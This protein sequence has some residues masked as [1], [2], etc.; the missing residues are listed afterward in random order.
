[1]REASKKRGRGVNYK[2]C[3]VLKSFKKYYTVVFEDGLLYP[4]PSTRDHRH[5]SE[6]E[7]S[8]NRETRKPGHQESVNQDIGKSVG[9]LPKGG[10]R[11]ESFQERGAWCMARGAA[12]LA[13]HHGPQ[14]E[15]ELGAGDLFL[16]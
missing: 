4:P 2:I 3:D 10:S 14:P 6:I 8:G 7:T 16:D 11:R 9:R 1:M 12:C 15:L 13:V 5:L